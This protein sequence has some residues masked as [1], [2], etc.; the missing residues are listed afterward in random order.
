MQIEQLLCWSGT[1]NV[2]WAYKIWFKRRRRLYNMGW[3][4]QK[5]DM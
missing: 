3:L 1:T 5:M 2:H 4:R